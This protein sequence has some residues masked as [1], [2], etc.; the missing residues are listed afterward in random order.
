[1]L[2]ARS[3]CED[4]QH[5]W[6]TGTPDSGAANALAAPKVLDLGA[7]MGCSPM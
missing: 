2:P 7:G 6:T 5:G 3:G 1:M 4:G